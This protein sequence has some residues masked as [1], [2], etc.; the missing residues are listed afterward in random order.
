MADTYLDTSSLVRRAELSGPNPTPRSQH[1]GTP[2]EALLD[3]P[4]DRVAT[5]EVGVLEFHDVV[6]GMWRDVNPPNTDYDEAWCEGALNAVMADI[7]A[8]RLLVLKQQS[9]LFEQAMTLVTMS[10][11]QHG[12]KFRVWDA[13]HLIT[14]V[15][16]SVEIGVA[17]ELWTTDTDFEG[18]LGLYPHFAAHVAVR[19][20]DL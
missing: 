15:S 7:G 19:S 17:V 12:R 8:E 3:A 2:V 18:F 11:R 1:A 14:A 9:R 13:A 5:S 20:L 10:T 4:P 6:T 16:W